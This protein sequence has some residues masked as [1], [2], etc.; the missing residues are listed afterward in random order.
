[1]SG[2]S[3]RKLA[4]DPGAKGV[5]AKEVKIDVGG[6]RLWRNWPLKIHRD[7]ARVS[8]LFPWPIAASSFPSNWKV[9]HDRQLPQPA[10][11]SYFYVV[12]TQ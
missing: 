6:Y 1:M 8:N 2:A 7:T 3:P 4:D 9:R 12:G 10:H 11:F 5:T